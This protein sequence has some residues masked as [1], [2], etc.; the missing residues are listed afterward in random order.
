MATKKEKIDFSSYLVLDASHAQPGFDFEAEGRWWRDVFRAR[1]LVQVD[2]VLSK[3][4]FLDR[5]LGRFFNSQDRCR[6]RYAILV[7]LTVDL[8]RR[9]AIVSGSRLVVLSYFGCFDLVH[10]G[11]NNFLLFNFLVVHLLNLGAGRGWWRLLVVRHLRSLL[12][13]EPNKRG[14]RQRKNGGGSS[15]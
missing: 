11:R 9:F 7:G 1:K 4:G 6:S 10:F 3:V 13:T 8:L 12:R 2:D 14:G 15:F 5:Q